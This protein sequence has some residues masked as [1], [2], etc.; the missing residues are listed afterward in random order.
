MHTRPPPPSLNLRFIGVKMSKSS[1]IQSTTLTY[2]ED[3]KVNNRKAHGKK[4]QAGSFLQ[5]SAICLAVVK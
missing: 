3:L 1:I 4:V 2:L 5:S